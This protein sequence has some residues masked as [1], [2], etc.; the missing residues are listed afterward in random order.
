MDYRVRLMP[1]A[2]R[3]LEEIFQYIQARSSSAAHSWFMRLTNA[4][5]GLSTFPQRH[6]ITPEYPSLRHLLF[7]NKPHIYRVIYL[8]D[9]TARSVDILSVWHGAQQPFTREIQ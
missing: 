3:D 5:D 8:I 6:P 9:V 7:G 4:I 1:R 2:E